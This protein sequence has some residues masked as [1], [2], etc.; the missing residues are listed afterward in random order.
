M[1]W[2]YRLIGL[3]VVLIVIAVGALFL[4]PTERIAAVATQQFE[5]ATGRALSF[6]G[7]V[8]PTLWPR[9]GA[10]IEG[11]SL[12]NVAGSDAGPMLSADS[13]D[14]GVGL[15]A[16]TGGALAIEHFE[17]NRPQ[18]VLERDANGQGNWVFSGL[19][20]ADTASDG[21]QT[22]SQDAPN[23]G[24]MIGGITVDRAVITDASLRYID[25]AAG[26][27]IT[28]DG[29][30]LTLSMPNSDG[31]A[32]LTLTARRG[33]SEGQVQAHV[34]SVAGLLGGEVTT[35]TATVS[36]D[37]L[38]A[39]FDGRAGLEPLAADGQLTLSSAQLAP[40][41][42]LAGIAG[43]EPLPPAARPLNLSGR[44]TLAP[45]GSIHLRE[46]VLGA[47]SNR[48]NAALDL[49]TSGERPSLTG[50][51]SA[52]RLDLSAFLTGGESAPSSGGQGWPTDR[53][54]ASALGLMDAQIGLRLG[55]VITGFGDLDQLQGSL[56]IDRSRA[57]LNLSDVRAFE[58]TMTGELVANNRSGLS[59]GGSMQL[60]GVSLQPLLSQA[61]GF[62]RLTGSAAMNVEFLGVGQSVDAIMRSL[63]GQ[64]RFDFGAGEI[65]GFDLAGMLRNL[66][67][68]YVGE[69]NRTIFDSLSGSYTVQNGVLRNDDLTLA[70]SLLSV[71]GDGTVDLGGQVLEY[72]VTPEAMR[73]ADTGQALR[74]PLL[75]TGPWSAPR[76]RLDLEGLAEQ[77]LEEERVRLEAAARAELA[78]R[79][80]EA[81]AQLEERLQQ[82]LNVT[83]QEGQNVEDAVRD[84]AENA[85]RD[86][87]L[88]LLGGGS[89]PAAAPA[90]DPAPTPATE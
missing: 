65:I 37:G 24:G 76:F 82:E 50:D 89:D 15:S 18:I 35:I 72:R 63:Q 45:T 6:S 1:R 47:G 78:R 30:D 51:L 33:G 11:V 77:R 86:G 46:G 64:G 66:D 21:A 59:V 53:I 56:V 67:A 79:E 31:P 4:I 28:I 71:L 60:Q 14:V 8:R 5:A 90:S 61:A 12:A 13:V 36:A 55:P 74:V 3:I 26:T 16:L 88:R 57:V 49:I 9:L 58:G 44:I 62:E 43:A 68:S 80:D 83:V 29:I 84:Q 7:S 2:I 70:A 54:D 69:G 75:I 48:I 23:T 85:V 19:S 87:L 17:V 38:E 27:D 34:G 20:G 39:S 40:A 10:R 81:R 32:D 41:L 22:G 25:R 52:D 42:A 73:N